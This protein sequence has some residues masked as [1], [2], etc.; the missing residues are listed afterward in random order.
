MSD[1]VLR[2][3]PHT[4]NPCIKRLQ[5]SVTQVDP[6]MWQ[7]QYVM[8]ADLSQV[9][10][11]AIMPAQAMDGLWQHT[12]FEAFVQVAGVSTYYEFNFSPSS[13]WA[14][15]AFQGYRA[16]DRTWQASQAPDIQCECLDTHALTLTA[17]LPTSLLPSNPHAQA[18]RIGLSAVI[19]DKQGVKSY[20]A[21][22]HVA[23]NPDFHQAASFIATL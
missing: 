16:G 7:L 22:S 15:Y 3:H 9:R 18:W 6:T 10:I 19:E 11:P 13:Q 2:A 8:Q 5:V 14:A 21:L 4:P 17:R 23:T 1:Y 12:C 20:W